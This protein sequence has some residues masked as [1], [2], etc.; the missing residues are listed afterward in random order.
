MCCW[1]GDPNRLARSAGG[2]KNNQKQSSASLV[3]IARHTSQPLPPSTLPC[4]SA[5]L[6]P[7]L[8]ACLLGLLA[9]PP[10]PLRSLT[11]P[12]IP[13]SLYSS[14]GLG[15]WPSRSDVC[16]PAARAE[17]ALAPREERA[18]L[19]RAPAPAPAPAH[20]GPLPLVAARR[21]RHRVAARGKP[22]AHLRRK[23][24]APA[25]ATPAARAGV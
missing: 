3:S 25:A 15:L 2:Q 9:V 22:A 12:S 4:L 5:S 18:G 14:L 23:A 21:P 13:S 24:P 20:P 11:P 1:L 19:L 16:E 10:S 17:L 8:P 7:C 6:P